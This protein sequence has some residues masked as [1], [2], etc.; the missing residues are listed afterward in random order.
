MFERVRRQLTLWHVGTLAL[1]L[2][3]FVGGIYLATSRTLTAELDRSLAEENRR[4]GQSLGLEWGSAGW[5]LGPGVEL[6]EG[7]LHHP[8]SRTPGSQ[9]GAGAPGERGGDG[10]EAEEPD[11]GGVRALPLE[12]EQMGFVTS[13]TLLLAP[14]GKLLA[15]STGAASLVAGGLLRRVPALREPAYETVASR[16]GAVRLYSAPVR[17]PSGKAVAFLVTARPTGALQSTL[18]GLL[19]VLAGAA[20]AALLAAA[21]A[22][23]LMAGRAL[24]PIR[25]AWEQQRSFIADAS[26]ELRT[27][28]AVIRGN[29]ELL[30]KRLAERGASEEQEIVADIQDES[31]RM[32]NLVEGLLTLARADAGRLELRQE[33]VDAPELLRTV[34]RRA[35]PLAGERGLELLAEPSAGPLFVRGDPER[36]MQALWILVDNALRYT[37]A[38][39]RVTLACQSSPRGGRAGVELSVADTG[40][41]IPPEQR[42]RLFDRFFRGDPARSSEGA[43]IGLSIAQAILRAHG[44]RVEVESAVGRGSR[45][46]LW[47]PRA[48]AGAEERRASFARPRPGDGAA[49][50]VAGER[51]SEP[52]GGAG[53]PDGSPS[54]SA[55][56]E[57]GPEEARPHRGA[58]EG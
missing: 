9:A 25:R 26:H 7:E 10:T 32:S 34:A 28:L 39:G 19:L 21:I 42:E 58:L 51:G 8:D 6:A 46:V 45:F 49:D 56:G 16:D 29:A 4:V 18:H 13:S 12:Q 44:G 52:G 20:G 48:S 3:L 40:P 53:A 5:R 36:L 50:E 1:V 2:L 14:D 54:R 17:D 37:P 15:G 27:P 57:G 30:A 33:P 43:G 47:L 41:G 22:G 35:R 24:V 55:V 38:P 31:L 11:E 23:S